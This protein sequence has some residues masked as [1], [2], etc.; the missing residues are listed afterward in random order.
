MLAYT[1]HD[2][3]IT[4]GIRALPPQDG[5]ARFESTGLASLVC[6]CGRRDGPMHKGL[7][8]LIAEL[9]IHGIA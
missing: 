3:R 2:V 9:H 6:S 7:I 4:Q 8:R 5:W 1:T